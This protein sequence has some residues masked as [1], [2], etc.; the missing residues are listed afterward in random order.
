VNACNYREH[1]SPVTGRG[2][3]DGILRRKVETR[4][5]SDVATS[6]LAILRAVLEERIENDG[7]PAKLYRPL[8][9]EGLLLLGHGGAKS[10][11]SDRFVSLSRVFAERT[12]LA[13]VC[14][15]TVDH[16]ERGPVVAG[17]TLPWLG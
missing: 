6:D 4:F 8:G 9:A 16:G 10:K 15:D 5:E 14:I 3:A 12:G 1:G 17:G 13:V 2:S 11:D 7:I